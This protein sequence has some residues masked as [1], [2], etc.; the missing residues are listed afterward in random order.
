MNNVNGTPPVTEEQAYLRDSSPERQALF[1]MLEV[2]W[3]GGDGD[4]PPKFIQK[5]AKLC[6][7]PLNDLQKS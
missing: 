6:G 7:F 4:A 2:Y 5:A 1:E 3:G